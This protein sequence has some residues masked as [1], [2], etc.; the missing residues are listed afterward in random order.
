MVTIDD[1]K[2][3]RVFM[4][5]DDTELASIVELCRERTFGK[6]AVCFSQGQRAMELHL[7]RTGKVDIVVELEQPSGQVEETV[8]TSVEGEIFGWSAVVEPHIYT[9]SARC[10][11]KTEDI[12][13]KGT[14]LMKL[15]EQNTGIGYVV[16][17][18]L[19]SAVSSRLTDI[20]QKLSAVMA[21]TRS[22][23]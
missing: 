14:D 18:N 8:H 20:R 5:L 15:F 19:S 13:I 7:C 16:M 17:R 6:G 12:C 9:A 4:G 1:L 10:V 23:K 2:K 11:E 22:K 3:F 21:E